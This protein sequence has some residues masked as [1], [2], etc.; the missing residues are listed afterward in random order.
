MVSESWT[1]GQV[2]GK[3]MPRVSGLFIFYYY[4]FSLSLSLSLF[5]F[6]ISL[7]LALPLPFYLHS[8][9]QIISG[10]CE[11]SF[12]MRFDHSLSCSSSW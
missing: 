4:F 7:S 9:C 8:F 3:K 2:A 12:G 1:T 5:F 6:Y 11:T 10:I